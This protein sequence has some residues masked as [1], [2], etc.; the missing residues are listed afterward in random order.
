MSTAVRF[1]EGGSWMT[2]GFG[3]VVMAWLTYALGFTGFLV[4]IFHDSLQ[5]DKRVRAWLI[6]SAIC[7][8][9]FCIEWAIISLFGGEHFG[10]ISMV[11][12]S[13]GFLARNVPYF[14]AACGIQLV[15]GTKP[16]I[17]NASVKALSILITL[18]A[19]SVVLLL[20]F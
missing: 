13:A 3:F 16:V 5:P 15:G 7:F 6:G 1:L 10:T 4:I 19:I 8:A 11:T 14:C 9:C 17:V 18:L 20:L 2:F 12:T